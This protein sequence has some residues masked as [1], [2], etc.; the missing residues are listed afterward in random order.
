MSHVSYL[1]IISAFLGEYSRYFVESLKVNY[2]DTSIS[3]WKSYIHSAA[4]LMVNYPGILSGASRWILDI[5]SGVKFTLEQ[6]TN[7][8]RNVAVLFGGGWST[9]RPGRFAPGKETRYPLWR[10]LGAGVENLA[11]NRIRSPYRPARSESLYRLRYPDPPLH[12]V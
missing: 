8:C 11:P 7:G 9:P 1:N 2:L 3:R 5:L 4:R 6:A 12:Y 10:R